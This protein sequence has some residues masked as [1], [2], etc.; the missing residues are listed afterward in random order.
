MSVEITTAFV[1]QYKGNMISLYQQRQSK[2]KGLVRE[3]ALT[4]KAHFFERLGATAAIKRTA[5][6]ADT[7]QVNSPHSRRMVVLAD[8]E[9]ADLI[10]D[11]DKIR[12][13]IN[14][15]SE[16]AVNGA[17]AMRRAYDDVVIESFDAIS[18]AGE[19]GET[20]VSF[21]SE[22]G[23]DE[24]FT[25]AALSV[26]NL[27][28]LKRSLDN[29]EVDSEGRCII[30]DPAG[31]EQLL[32]QGSASTPNLTSSD[33]ASVKAL[34]RGEIDTFLGFRFVMSTRMPKQ[35]GNKSYGFAW[36]KDSLAVAIGKDITTRI[37]ELP[38][39]S[40]AVQVYLCQTLG[41]TRVQGAGVVRFQI[42]SDN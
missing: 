14:P 4:G 7:P 28:K 21:A 26:A 19:K 5:R 10:D 2:L 9:W 17:S 42:D 1:Q 3:E 39:K 36:Q 8:Y 37:S 11:Q 34:V 22:A 40:Y 6:H 18:K 29:G 20:D 16:Y 35:T 12:I 13:L 31:F 30:M 24:D 23:G 41:A 38:T 25:G 15:E 33:Y 27:L 32:K